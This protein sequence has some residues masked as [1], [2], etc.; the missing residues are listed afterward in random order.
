VAETDTPPSDRQ[1]PAEPPSTSLDTVRVPGLLDHYRQR[2]RAWLA[3]ADEL[4]RLRGEVRVAAEREAVEIVTAARRDV[5]RIVV[6]ARRELLVLTA[7]LHASVEAA[8]QSAAASPMPEPAIAQLSADPTPGILGDTRDLVR[9]ARR[10]VRSVLD[11]ARAEIDALIADAPVPVP[12]RVRDSSTTHAA[13]QR[14]SAPNAA[15][16]PTMS[17]GR[18]G[19][20]E[21]PTARVEISPR[22]PLTR[23]EA[24][25][26]SEALLRLATPHSATTAPGFAA[27]TLAEHPTA[28]HGEVVDVEDH[29]SLG[30]LPT[31][32]SLTERHEPNAPDTHVVDPDILDRPVDDEWLAGHVQPVRTADASRMEIRVPS[33]EADAL[34]HQ[35]FDAHA[36]HSDYL[37]GVFASADTEQASELGGSRRSRFVQVAAAAGVVLLAGVFW[38][39]RP[40]STPVTQESRAT[41]Q[42]AASATAAAPEP[43]RPVVDDSL[44]LVIEARRAAWI[45]ATIDG[46][47][48]VG[49]MYRAGETRQ[50]VGA[51]SVAIRAGDAGAVYVSIDGS[52][53][54]SLG[55]SGAVITRT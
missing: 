51:R 19:V 34:T 3:Q 37:S 43:T 22:T 42:T 20:L 15:A 45:R 25:L 5:R 1:S 2:H 28:R 38:W 24:E 16:A 32:A 11:E 21:G 31:V 52:G 29:D 46:Q 27:V 54:T 14:P 9:G 41:E 17:L 4:I 55:D 23:R 26:D 13:A 39:Q 44:S 30:P 53:A 47:E 10:D 7:Q 33:P 8:D 18:D 12:V 36:E 35:A 40:G 49:R 50:I 6:E 48:E